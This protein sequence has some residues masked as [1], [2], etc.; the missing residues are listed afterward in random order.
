VPAVR[1]VPR[2]ARHAAEL[3]AASALPGNQVEDAALRVV[4][5]ALLTAEDAIARARAEGAGR[6]A[7]LRGGSVTVAEAA[8]GY[9]LTLREVRW[10][11]DVVVSGDIEWPGRSGTVHANLEL[12]AP[13]N[14]HGKLELQ[15][16]EGVTRA[17]ATVRGTLG[18]H[19]V[20]AEAAAP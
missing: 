18:A 11:E 16:P 4:S 17:R 10:T 2:F 14:L 20:A 7:G 1:L 8:P 9:H 12:S 5:A 6:G 19:A 13:E 15:W 3:A